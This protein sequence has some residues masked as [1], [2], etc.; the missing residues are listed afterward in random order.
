MT[1]TKDFINP[2]LTRNYRF[3]TGVP[4]S[5]LKSLI[6]FTLMSR[7]TTYIT[8]ASEGEAIAIAIG[9]YLAGQKSVVLCQNSGLGNTINPLTSLCHPFRI[10]L[11]LIVSHRGSPE[12]ADEPQ[13]ALMGIITEDLLKTLKIPF[14]IFPN[15]GPDVDRILEEADRYMD[16]E[17]RPFALIVKKNALTDYSLSERSFRTTQAPASAQ[18]SFVTPPPERMSRLE[19]IKIVR[20]HFTDNALLLGT[21]GKTGR[22]LFSLGH[23]S[24]QLYVVGGMGCASAIGLGLCLSQSKQRKVVIFDGDGAI[25]MKMGTLATIGHYSPEHLIHIALDNEVHESTGGQETVSP[26]IDLAQIASSCSY[27]HSFRADTPEGLNRIVK[28]A[29]K[30]SGPTFIHLKIKPGSDPKL[31]RPTLS[32]EEVKKEFMEYIRQ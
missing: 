24:N 21:T 4:C 6:N 30:I 22:E 15:D 31:G 18:G 32:P 17:N 25:L 10:P 29:L 9:S 27:R 2:F 14:R 19:A 5:F 20:N 13:H 16:R 26:S 1:E 3:W 8:A 11:L 7:E 23:K 28:N 12:L